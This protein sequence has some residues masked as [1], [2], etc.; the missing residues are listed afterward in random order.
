MVTKRGEVT[1]VVQIAEFPQFNYRA[2]NRW[3]QRYS[4]RGSESGSW[5]DAARSDRSSK[6]REYEYESDTQ[7][8]SSSPIRSSAKLL[9]SSKSNASRIDSREGSKEERRGERSRRHN[10][11]GI[12]TLK[13][14]NWE[15]EVQRTGC[16]RSS[17]GSS[18]SARRA[19]RAD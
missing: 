2:Y 6:C 16:R 9:K 1:K 12:A 18:R 11:V 8:P 19:E 17:S 3:E 5:R 10:G 15:A 13:A 7:R 14:T 4:M